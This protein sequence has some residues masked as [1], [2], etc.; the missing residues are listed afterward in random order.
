MKPSFGAAR[1]NSFE[2]RAAVLVHSSSKG[3]S[4][5]KGKRN[6]QWRLDGYPELLEVLLCLFHW[7]KD[8][9]TAL[10]CN[11]PERYWRLEITTTKYF[12]VITCN[13]RFFDQQGTTGRLTTTLGCVQNSYRCHYSY[14]LEAK[15]GQV[16][17]KPFSSFY[18]TVLYY[19]LFS[20]QSWY[21]NA[22][23]TVNHTRKKGW[24]YLRDHSAIPVCW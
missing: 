7:P 11:S 13:F 21:K 12:L 23:K 2:I 17:P 5:M 19:I 1:H 14:K 16:I 8:K 22:K 18:S 10:N 3:Q 4:M 6:K 20:R 9:I 15:L 24:E